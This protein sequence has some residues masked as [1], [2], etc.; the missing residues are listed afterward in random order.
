MITKYII[1]MTVLPLL[2]IS[3]VIV[4]RVAKL[5]SMRHPEFGPHREEGSCGS[6]CKCGGD[7]K[8]NCKNS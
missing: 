2:L 7:K 6:S 8:A 1:A 5:Y 4:Q 3:W